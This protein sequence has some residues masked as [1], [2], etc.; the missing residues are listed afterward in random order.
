MRK[1]VLA[2]VLVLVA[3][4]AQAAT[5]NVVGGQLIGASGVIVNGNTYDVEFQ[6]GSCIDLYNDCDDPV[7]DFTFQSEADANAASQA[8]LDQ[9]WFGI[10]LAAFL[11]GEV[12]GDD[13][14]GC[15][16][17][18]IFGICQALTPWNLDP[19]LSPFTVRIRAAFISFDAGS[20]GSEVA[21]GLSGG[22]AEPGAGYHGAGS[23][24]A[25]WSVG[26]VP[27]PGTGLLMGLGLLG[28]SVSNR[29]QR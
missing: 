21:S 13:W 6:T 16:A 29:R 15:D 19:S 26:S 12:L 4:S 5:L 20:F 18:G 3:S 22:T 24:Y 28:V 14:L 1:F 25:V 2:V 17:D 27:E 23:V 11:T 8:I 7:A 10:D 9:V